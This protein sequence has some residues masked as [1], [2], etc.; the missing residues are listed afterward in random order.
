MTTMAVP[1]SMS[2]STSTMMGVG[3]P[4]VEVKPGKTGELRYTAQQ[5]GTL[6]IGCHQPDHWKAGMRATIDVT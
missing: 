3:E 5:A 1:T 4:V 6:L 2:S